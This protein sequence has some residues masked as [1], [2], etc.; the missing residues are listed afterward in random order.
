MC[1]EN[2]KGVEPTTGLVN[3]FRDK[4]GGVALLETFDIF[5]RVV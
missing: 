4:V 5:E 1:T 2:Q 3:T